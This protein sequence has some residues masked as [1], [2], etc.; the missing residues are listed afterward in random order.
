MMELVI[1]YILGVVFVGMVSVWYVKG[2]DEDVTLMDIVNLVFLTLVSW[3][4]VL[5]FALYVASDCIGKY[6]CRIIIKKGQKEDK[7]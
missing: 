6:L 7:E 1:I 3:L 2:T 5:L 4:A